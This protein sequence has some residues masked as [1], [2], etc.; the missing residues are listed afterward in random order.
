MQRIASSLSRVVLP[1]VK[2]RQVQSVAV[3]RMSPA[4]HSTTRQLS[5]RSQTTARLGLSA[6]AL[7]SAAAVVTGTQLFADGAASE[8]AKP[9]DK[10][11]KKVMTSYENRI[12]T[13]STPEKIFSTFASKSRKGKKYMTPDD[14]MRSLIPNYNM[15]D[16][17]NKK[18]DDSIFLL[19]DADGDGLIS[20]REYLFFTRLLATPVQNIE[21]AFKMFDENGDGVVDQSEFASVMAAQTRKDEGNRVRALKGEQPSNA[22]LKHFFGSGDKK[23]SFTEFAEFLNGLQREVHK[24]EFAFYD[25]QDKGYMNAEEFGQFL[26]AHARVKDTQK[27]AARVKEMRTHKARISAEQ[28]EVFNT[29]LKALNRVENAIDMVSTVSGSFDRATLRRAAHAVVGVHLS[30]DILD[31]IWAVFDSNKD[32]N[33]DYDEFLKLMKKRT[34]RALDQP[35]DTGLVRGLH[36]IWDCIRD[37]EPNV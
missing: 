35:R 9:D 11:K 27:L 3:T 6:F 13:F 4:M 34:A 8:D 33:L 23:L 12:R 10:F 30:D 5:I 15:A 2:S 20:F 7:V 18:F 29:V 16:R 31:V 22:L 37:S 28:F 1:F 17:P 19:A 25:S 32:G 26:V 14:F 24:R 36:R 21:L